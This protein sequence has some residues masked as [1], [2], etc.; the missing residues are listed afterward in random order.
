PARPG[1]CRAHHPHQRQCA[2]SALYGCGAILAGQRECVAASHGLHWPGGNPA[3]ASLLTACHGGTSTGKN[4]PLTTSCHLPP[5]SAYGRGWHRYVGCACSTFSP[6][7]LALPG[8][9][10]V[11]SGHHQNIQTPCVATA[12]TLE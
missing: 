5:G 4:R 7:C 1:L 8:H 2:I 11:G 10:T 9:C 12:Q 6:L 3:A